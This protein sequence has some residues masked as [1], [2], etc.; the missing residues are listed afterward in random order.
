MRLELNRNQIIETSKFHFLT[1]LFFP[2]A[3]LAFGFALAFGLGFSAAFFGSG[4]DCFAAGTAFVT[5]F[6]AG[7]AAF[8]IFLVFSSFFTSGFLALL[9]DFEPFLVSLFYY[10]TAGSFLPDFFCFSSSLSLFFLSA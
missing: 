1:L 7:V 3:G 6:F 4:G 8:L 5:A 10:F 2:L 9:L